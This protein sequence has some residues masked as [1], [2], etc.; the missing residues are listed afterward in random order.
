MPAAFMSPRQAFQRIRD[1]L[2]GSKFDRAMRR[3]ERSGCHRFLFGW[4][5]GLGDV[6]LGLTPYFARIRQ[7]FDNA[8]IDVITREDLAPVFELAGADAIHVVPGLKR[9]AAFEVAAEARRLGLDPQGYAG[10]FGNADLRRW[11]Q[12]A[13]ETVAPK[14]HWPARLDGLA[15]RF[16]E[17]EAPGPWI[18]VHVQSETEK[19][20]R[21]V[22]DWPVQRW[23]QLFAAVQAK[24][25]AKFVLLG[26]AA[27][28]R[29]AGPGVV[30]LRGR[31]TL[32]EAL[33]LVRT[34]FQVLVAPDSGI[35]SLVYLLDMQ[36][37]LG[38]V[39]L[40]ADPRQGILKLAQPSPNARLR[41]HPLLGRNEEVGN[42]SVEEVA[43]AV[44]DCLETPP[45]QGQH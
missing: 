28:G 39:S 37:D 4:N 20:Y 44:L 19:F 32:L 43:A 42:I 9:G 15:T 21:Y 8:S 22:K 14:L 33:S 34:R 2:L 18:G 40:W 29:L 26:V 11:E 6:G 12:S 45:G 7:A 23:P 38:V 41:H 30:D 16:V 5:R 36:K 35:L 13:R 3:A 17:L 25:P 31:T 1:L 27:G 24:V 10:V